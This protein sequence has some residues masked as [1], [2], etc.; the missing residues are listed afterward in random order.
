MEGERGG[1]G[2]AGVGGEKVEKQR[3]LERGGETDVQVEK[4]DG[5]GIECP[6]FAHLSEIPLHDCRH[7]V[8]CYFN[9]THFLLSSSRCRHIRFSR[10]NRQHCVCVRF[11]HRQ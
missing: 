7:A 10:A 2:E 3:D 1:G 8:L 4:K 5:R 6:V 9:K 11:S